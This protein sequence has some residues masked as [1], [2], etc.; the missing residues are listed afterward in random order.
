MRGCLKPLRAGLG[1]LRAG[2]EP[3]SLSTLAEK[4]R[5][6][7]LENTGFSANADTLIEGLSEVSGM[8]G[9]AEMEIGERRYGK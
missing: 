2:I 8:V 4:Q 6:Y 7:P 3:L 1:L 9:R 5:V